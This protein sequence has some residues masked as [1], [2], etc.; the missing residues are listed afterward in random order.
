MDAITLIYCI[1]ILR[2]T[3]LDIGS[4]NN[5]GLNLTILSCGAL[6][7]L[8]D[9]SSPTFTERLDNVGNIGI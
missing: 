9:L 2:G 6:T 7:H 3:R 1:A 4:D 5:M 8:P